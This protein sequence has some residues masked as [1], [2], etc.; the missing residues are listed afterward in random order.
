MYCGQGQGRLNSEGSEQ[1]EAGKVKQ[2][3]IDDWQR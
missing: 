3:K 1:G 2:A